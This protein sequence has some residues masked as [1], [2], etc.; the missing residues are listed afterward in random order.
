MTH[1]FQA[2]GKRGCMTNN[3]ILPKGIF[4]LLNNDSIKNNLIQNKID[5]LWSYN[6]SKSSDNWK[7]LV[8]ILDQSVKY[9]NLNFN[10]EVL[11]SKIIKELTR[12]KYLSNEECKKFIYLLSGIGLDVFRCLNNVGDK[13][14]VLKSIK[15]FLEEEKINEDRK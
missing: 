4:S 5:R 6:V 3:T 15:G 7:N 9:Y 1:G 13:E 2:E 12:C 14:K 8:I 11:L 10:Q